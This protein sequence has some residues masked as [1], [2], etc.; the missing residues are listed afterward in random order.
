MNR[1]FLFLLTNISVIVVLTG[2]L[3]GIS[4]FL[5]PDLAELANPRNYK[6]ILIF[7]V[8][9]GFGGSFI[10]LIM[11]KW[12]AI[13]SVGA[14]KIDPKNPKSETEL[15]I[16]NTIKN[17]SEKVGI[18]MPEI[19]WFDGEPNAFATGWSK[20]HSLVAVS[21]GLIENMEA[22]EIEAVIAHEIS[23][24]V[25]GDMI[26]MTLLQGVVNTFVLFSS[27]II[28]NVITGI[29]KSEFL[30]GVIYFVTATILQIIFGFLASFITMWFSRH[31]EYKADKMGGELTSPE[32]MANAL[33][34]LMGRQLTPLA[35]G[36]LAAN[37]FSN[38]IS[39]MG[40][41]STHPT[42]ESRIKRL[43]FTIQ[44]NV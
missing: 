27:R 20:N 14:I 13:R 29:F 21:N 35:K 10:S 8:V 36:D 1:L 38:E 12:L 7:S 41:L 33:Y 4:L 30:G 44:N 24:I 28:A 22:P 40:L 9:I 15:Y 25:N 2:V 42:L 37:G 17:L 11:S 19:A 32:Q 34:R 31:R 18:K 43:G 6:T 3:Y 39:F 5:P 23:H 16:V 26:T